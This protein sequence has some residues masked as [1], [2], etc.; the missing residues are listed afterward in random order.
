MFSITNDLGQG[1]ACKAKLRKFILDNYFSRKMMHATNIPCI[2][3][4]IAKKKFHQNFL[5]DSVVINFILLTLLK[6]RNLTWRQF[7]EGKVH[8]LGFFSDD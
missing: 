7:S 5:Q 6:L 2:T 8:R 3:F 1:I 4:S